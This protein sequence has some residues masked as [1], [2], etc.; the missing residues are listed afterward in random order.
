MRYQSSWIL[1]QGKDYSP[2][3][4]AKWRKG[5]DLVTDGLRITRTGTGTNKEEMVAPHPLFFRF[6]LRQTDSIDTPPV[7]NSVG[8]GR[9]NRASQMQMRTNVTDTTPAT[10]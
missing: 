7:D 3:V 4:T 2:E 6:R 5:N 1:S 10:G 9:K 8:A